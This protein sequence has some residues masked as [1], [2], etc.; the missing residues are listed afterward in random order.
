M[1][2][3]IAIGDGYGAGF[4][5]A[6]PLKIEHFNTLTRYE[7]HPQNEIGPGRYTDDTQMSLAVAE[8]ILS[9]KK[10]TKHAFAKSFL[11]CFKRDP[12][13]GYSSRFYDILS[14]SD[15]PQAMLKALQPGSTRNGAM[16]R[17][18]PLGILSTLPE[19]LEVAK[20][21]ASVTHNSYWGILSSQVIAVCAYSIINNKPIHK[22]P[23][24]IEYVFGDIGIDYHW[25]K[26]V[27]CDARET[28]NA[29]MTLLR[30]HVDVVGGVKCHMSTL[31]RNSVNFGGDV[32]SVASIVLGLASLD[33]NIIND[34][35]D[36]LTSDLE[37]GKYGRDYLMKLDETIRDICWNYSSLEAW[38]YEKGLLK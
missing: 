34:L 32:D 3:E 26:P 12:R 25:D 9:G 1:L 7:Q 22:L 24:I 11:D 20:I 16:M 4:E 17:S 6:D 19:V 28:L 18:V 5:F 23:G 36:F 27:A 30:H 15:S 21:Q 37:N 2:L 38:K 8:L 14:A 35:P 10:L 13:K 33:T 29:V 31:L